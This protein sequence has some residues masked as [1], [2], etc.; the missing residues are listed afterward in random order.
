MEITGWIPQRVSHNLHDGP[1]A[2]L[3]FSFSKA[4]Y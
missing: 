2:L 4:T 3:F 1:L